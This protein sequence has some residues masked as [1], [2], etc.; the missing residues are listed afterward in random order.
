MF[1]FDKECADFFNMVDNDVDSFLEKVGAEAENI[2][3]ESGN[4]HDRTGNLRRSNFHQVEEHEL[5]IGN[6]A[7]YAS[8]VSSMGY[9][10][11]DSGVMYARGK[12]EGMS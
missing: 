10:V 7:D 12:I 1:D 9:D 5:K 2:N 6:T 3:K 11:I 8:K 4:Y